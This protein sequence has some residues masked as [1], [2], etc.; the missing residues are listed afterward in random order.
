MR[1]SRDGRNPTDKSVAGLRTLIDK[2]LRM[3]ETDE[4]GDNNRGYTDLGDMMQAKVTP[5]QH[6][7]QRDA[8]AQQGGD[9]EQT[10]ACLFLE[11]KGHCK[12]GD[13]CKLTHEGQGG[14]QKI[15]RESSRKA[16]T[17]ECP[18]ERTIWTNN[19]R[20]LHMEGL[21]T[22]VKLTRTREIQPE[23]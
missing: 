21:N 6:M 1:W 8:N 12:H 5:P 3:V 13:K 4:L 18:H 17:S 10:Q 15:S 9:G 14:A 19:Q 7:V 20:Q 16:I 22:T 23:I 11:Q 2:K